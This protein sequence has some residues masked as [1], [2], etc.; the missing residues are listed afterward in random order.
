MCQIEE[1][2]DEHT[3]QHEDV[4]SQLIQTDDY[5]GLGVADKMIRPALDPFP[6]HNTTLGF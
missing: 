6:V 4:I 1:D 3:A 2:L 5:C